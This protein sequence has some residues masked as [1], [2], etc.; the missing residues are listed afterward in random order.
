MEYPYGLEYLVPEV[1]SDGLSNGLQDVVQDRA[2]QK[3]A[4][5]MRSYFQLLMN[6]VIHF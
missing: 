6:P 4:F 5:I 2:A 1:F 3:K